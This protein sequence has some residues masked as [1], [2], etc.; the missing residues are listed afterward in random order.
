M[1]PE[2]FSAGYTAWIDAVATVAVHLGGKIALVL[3]LP[4]Y[5]QLRNRLNRHRDELNSLK[6]ST[7]TEPPPPA[8]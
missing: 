7:T 6:P 2:A 1:T 8:P 4:A 3:A 5:V